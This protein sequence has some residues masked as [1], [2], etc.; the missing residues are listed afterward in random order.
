V[1]SHAAKTTTPMAPNNVEELRE[2]ATT[3]C[4]IGASPGAPCLQSNWEISGSNQTL[5][6]SSLAML[7]NTMNHAAIRCFC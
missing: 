4:Q 3:D 7:K 6:P 2:Q 1:S 5:I